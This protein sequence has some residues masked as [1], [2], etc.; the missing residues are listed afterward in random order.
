MRTS[1]TTTGNGTV[2]VRRNT[3]PANDLEWQIQAEAVR[4]IKQLPGYGDEWV[5]GVDFTIAGDF[6]AARRSRQES[7][8]AKAT[9]IAAGEP[10]LR[11][12]ILGGWL[13]MIEFKGAKTPV[14][15]AQKTRHKLLAGLGFDVELLRARTIEEGASAAVGLVAGWLAE[16]RGENRRAA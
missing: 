3:K 13:R 8:K 1:R 6:N 10:D 16:A 14:S 5:D 2:V 9:G 7:V 4:R 12:Y 11:V 15:A